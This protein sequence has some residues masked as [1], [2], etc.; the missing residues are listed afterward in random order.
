VWAARS[1]IYRRVAER[2]LPAP[3]QWEVDMIV[4]VRRAREAVPRWQR[5]GFTCLLGVLLAALLDPGYVFW[6]MIGLVL[7]AIGWPL[8]R[9]RSRIPAVAASLAW[10]VYMI[11][12]QH[13]I[14]LA[15]LTL[16]GRWYCSRTSAEWADYQRRARA[17]GWWHARW[18]EL[19]SD[20]DNREAAQDA[21]SSGAPTVPL[22]PVA[23]AAPAGEA[24]SQWAS[25]QRHDPA[26]P[27][28][29]R[30][31][32]PFAVPVAAERRVRMA[33]LVARWPAIAEAAGMADTTLRDVQVNPWGWE[34]TW[35]L[36]PGQT[37]KHAAQA[38][39]ALESALGVRLDAVR[40]DKDPQDARQVR[41]RVVERD[42]LAAPILRPAPSMGSILRPLLAGVYEDAAPCRLP[43]H[44]QHV[45]IV[46]AN[47]A[48]K[49]ALLRTLVEEAIAA[50]DV[51]V[52][53]IDLKRGAGLAP[54]AAC[55]GQLATTPEQA[56][57]LLEAAVA[58]LEARAE[59][60]RGDHWPASRTHPVLWLVVDEHAELV[61]TCPAAVK[62]E[63][64]IVHRGRSLG[65][66]LL[67]TALRAT[68]DALG[69]DELRQ[70]F[71]TRICLSLEDPADA[72]LLFGRNAAKQGW[73]PELLD[74]PG[75]F[76]VRSRS[77]GLTRPR[78]A[79][80]FADDPA[81]TR[82][83]V[84]RYARPAN[85]DGTQPSRLEPEAIAA[86][87]TVPGALAPVS[88]PSPGP[89]PAGPTPT[90][91]GTAAAGTAPPGPTATPTGSGT[92]DPIGALLVE[93]HAAGPA[94][95]RIPELALR[96]GQP[97][98][99]VHAHLVALE[100]AG[101][102]ERAG[103]RRWRI[104]QPRPGRGATG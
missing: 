71:R 103:N 83:V 39:L 10:A 25:G 6:A 84:A 14:P 99:T 70:Q 65:V 30:D 22:P 94:G 98:P 31:G 101:Q 82:Q 24:A 52:W 35:R 85:P 41:L 44:E 48:G 21:P 47:G 3:I 86:A 38:K 43:L 63:E 72:D 40:V 57:R 54:Y 28:L 18:D 68:Q 55:L 67:C 89:S 11:G 77:H 4:D 62:L 74:A 37:W 51:E 9:W 97:G 96:T 29:L 56:G 78:L 64:S 60:R 12:W 91:D 23:V 59:Q 87:R 81:I 34:A 69:S 50:I 45:L 58:V 49:T 16:F 102:V 53:G 42:P 95:A 19:A 13:T 8:L 5:I 90:P 66:H 61:R 7:T 36:R 32:D 79:R 1:W 93:L 76:F 33:D 46:A 80:G 20:E 92:P 26:R 100:A 15:G 27:V 104:S 73:D 88:P 17:Q 75:K 2:S